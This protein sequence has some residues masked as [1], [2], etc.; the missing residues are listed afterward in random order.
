[1]ILYQSDEFFRWKSSQTEEEVEEV[2]RRRQHYWP[3][4]DIIPIDYYEDTHIDWGATK[5]LQDSYIR[6]DTMKDVDLQFISK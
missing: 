5:S 2:E 3:A 1:M 6:S 4:F